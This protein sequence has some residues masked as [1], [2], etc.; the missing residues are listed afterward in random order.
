MNGPRFQAVREYRLDPPGHSRGV[1]CDAQGPALGPIRLLVKTAAGL[2]PR[3]TEELSAVLGYTFGR[4]LDCSRLSQG[5]G[6]VS[7]ALNEGD[8][9]RAMIATT[10][11]GLPCLDEE[12]ARRAAA[13]MTKAAPDDPEHPGWPAGTEGG[14]GGKFRPKDKSNEDAIRLAEVQLHR[15]IA[16]RAIR[17]AIRKILTPERALRLTGEAA[18]NL[19]PV[20]DVI[21][22]AAMAIDLAQMAA[23]YA[24]LK[25]DTAAAEEFARKAP[26]RLDDLRVSMEEKSFSSFDAF[27]KVDLVKYFGPAGDGYEYHHIVEQSADGDIS[28]QQLNTTRNIIRIPKLLHEEINSDFGRSDPDSKLSVRDMLKGKSFDERWRKGIKAMHDMGILV[29]EHRTCP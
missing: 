5:L 22:D 1:S 25:R 8:F 17:L 7:R 13:I 4:P 11:L 27:K 29:Q 16:R 6:A 19:I 10:Q 26:Y 24:T 23:E 14:R 2:A 15:L 21:G 20:I 3:P 18:S 9:A 12:E 28:T